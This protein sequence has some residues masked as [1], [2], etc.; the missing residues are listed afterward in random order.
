MSDFRCSANKL[1]ISLWQTRIRNIYGRLCPRTRIV[2]NEKKRQFG[3][4]HLGEINFVVYE[5][6]LVPCLSSEGCN[7]EDSG[8]RSH[9][10]QVFPTSV[11]L[12]R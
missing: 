2:R 5:Y 6:L 8:L 7:A 1:V 10:Y 9:E 11:S 3:G 4:S 12:G